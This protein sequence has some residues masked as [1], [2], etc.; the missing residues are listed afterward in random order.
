MEFH[1]EFGFKES[2]L[3]RI[4]FHGGA[5][6]NTLRENAFLIGITKRKQNVLEFVKPVAFL[7]TILK[8]KFRLD[9]AFAQHSTS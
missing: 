5:V 4:S 8:I 2:N 3:V 9:S 7:E 6:I 1:F